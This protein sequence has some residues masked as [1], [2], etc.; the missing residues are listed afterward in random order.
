MGYIEDFLA[1]VIVP[2]LATPF[3]DSSFQWKQG[4]N[5]SVLSLWLQMTQKKT[6]FQNFYQTPVYLTVTFKPEMVEG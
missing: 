1:K 4:F 3:F 5:M 2:W 6:K